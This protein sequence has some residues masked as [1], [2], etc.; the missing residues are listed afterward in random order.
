[1]TRDLVRARGGHLLG[2]TDD[3]KSGASDIRKIL[4]HVRSGARGSNGQKGM[5]MDK[6]LAS[7]FVAGALLH[8]T[9][10]ITV[11]A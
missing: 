11:F 2:D 4:K 3:T 1:M 7:C 10:I 8:W 5:G 9:I 6:C